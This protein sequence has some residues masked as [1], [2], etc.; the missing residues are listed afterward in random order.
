MDLWGVFFWK[1]AVV[2]IAILLLLLCYFVDSVLREREREK[3][4]TSSIAI[5]FFIV[6]YSS[7]PY[8]YSNNFR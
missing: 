2:D 3:L 8:Y 1:D 6:L 5:T 7:T 4:F